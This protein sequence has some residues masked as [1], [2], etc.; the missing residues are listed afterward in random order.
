MAV[1]A[2]SLSLPSFRLGVLLLVGVAMAVVLVVVVVA[3]GST[4]EM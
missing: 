3:W 4:H 2:H 1:P